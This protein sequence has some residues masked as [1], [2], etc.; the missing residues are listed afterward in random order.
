[1]GH[2][3]GKDIFR[4]LGRKIDGLATRS[5]WNAQLYAILKSLY[6]LEEAELIVKMNSGLS[7]L[8][9][10]AA[11]TGCP[12][13]QLRPRLEALADKGLVLDLLIGET[14]HYQPSPMVIGIFEFTMMRTRGKLESKQWAELFR[15]YLDGSD[16]FFAANQGSVQVMRSLPHE[17]AVLPSEFTEVLDYEKATAIVEGQERWAIGICS[18]RHEKHHLGERECDVPL[19]SCTSFGLAADYL[20]RHGFARDVTKEEM[21]ERV[22]QSWESGLVINA[23]NVKHK[24]TFLC[25]CCACCC[26]A[27]HGISKHGFPGTLVT[28]NYIAETRWEECNG[29]RNCAQDCPIDAMAMIPSPE[30]QFRKFGKPLVDEEL[31]LGCGVCTRR[32]RSGSLKLHPRRQRV[33]HPETTFERVIL[34]SLERGT[35]Q[36]QIFGDPQS[37]SQAFMR[38]VLGGFL[39][40]SPVKKAL[41]SDLLR[42]RFLSGMKKSVSSQG[43]DWALDL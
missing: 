41:M 8:E 32:C 39:R 24:P 27:L 34:Q 29:C 38:G 4:E 9:S 35:L 5:P 2:T 18:C 3:A 30:T 16:A 11:S 33:M 36:N 42:S 28:S 12:P 26:H 31:C 17:P 13:D 6:S 19:E 1:M 7:S 23:D 43:K 40:L 20:V 14:F 22:Q 10:V 15:A 37:K 21:L 25:H